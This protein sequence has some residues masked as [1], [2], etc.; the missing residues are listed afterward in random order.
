MEV[1][2]YT[3]SRPDETDGGFGARKERYDSELSAPYYGTFEVKEAMGLSKYKGKTRQ[4]TIQALK[5]Q[6]W[7]P[8]EQGREVSE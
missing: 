2:C 4:E 8:T 5:D 7:T 1:W 6:N 3:H